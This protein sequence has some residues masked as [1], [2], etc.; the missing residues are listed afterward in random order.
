MLKVT[1]LCTRSPAP[2]DQ[3]EH[4]APITACAQEAFHVRRKE[5]WPLTKAETLINKFIPQ[6]RPPESCRKASHSVQA[7]PAWSPAAAC[8]LSQ[9]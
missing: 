2:S 7:P 9:L 5:F 3:P 4:R 8:T 1:R 6:A